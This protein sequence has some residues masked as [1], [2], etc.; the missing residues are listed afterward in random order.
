MAKQQLVSCQ[1]CGACCVTQSS[2]PGYVI[3]MLR[4]D[5]SWPVEADVTR[6]RNLPRDAME[7][8]DDYARELKGDYN[9]SDERT[10]CWLDL[11]SRRCRWYEHRPQICREMKRGGKSCLAWRRSHVSVRG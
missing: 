6:F 10:C 5:G 4:G 2:P 8:L 1:H 7:V 11:P 3:L 9:V